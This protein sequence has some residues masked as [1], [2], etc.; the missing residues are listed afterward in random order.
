MERKIQVQ[1]YSRQSKYSVTDT[2]ILVPTTLKRYGLSEIINHLL[3]LDIPVPFDFIIDGKF[4]RTSIDTYLESN[5]KSTE[6]ILQVEFIELSLPPSESSS[7]IHDD[8]ISATRLHATDPYILSASFDSNL[9]VWNH[10][11][12]LVSEMVNPTGNN[13]LKCAEWL[14]NDQ[15]IVGDSKHNVLGFNFRDDELQYAY[16][17][18]GHEGSIE[19]LAVS[20]PLGMFASASWDKTIKL[21][22]ND[23]SDIQTQTIS[24]KSNKKQKIQE[25]KIKNE[26]SSLEGHVGA[27]SSI[28]FDESNRNGL[29]SGSWDHSVRLWDLN[30]ESNVHTMNCEQVVSCI[31]YSV[32]NGLLI[33]GHSDGIIRLWDPRSK[34]GLLVKMK[35][36]SHKNWVSSIT[37][38]KTI[39]DQFASVSYDG[40]LKVWDIRSTTPLYTVTCG[41]GDKMF[42]VDWQSG[43]LTTG[44][45]E[46]KLHVYLPHNQSV[47]A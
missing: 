41:E 12:T 6:N 46:G 4:L 31:D 43:L 10:S 47:G 29:F 40:T 45:E 17:C 42:S 7:L 35:L 38:S 3:A 11:S 15:I 33:T 21:W 44:G 1:F 34:D 5:S 32:Q 36:S 16:A 26:K 18:K 8:W 37:L 13:A 24:K 23:D 27:V 9:R 14:S 30:L 20:E 39:S 25:V 19:D 22:S 28:V 2:P